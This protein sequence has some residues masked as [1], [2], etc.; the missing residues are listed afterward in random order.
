MAYDFLG[1]VNDINRRSNEVELT[2][3]N[4]NT[5]TGYYSAIKDSVNSS[6]NFHKSTRI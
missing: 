1:I 2:T 5:V 4:F 3:D 6:I